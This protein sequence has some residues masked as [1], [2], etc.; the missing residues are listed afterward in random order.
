MRTRNTTFK[1]HDHRP[2]LFRE[3]DRVQVTYYGT[4]S[5]AVGTFVM[6]CTGYL[7]HCMVR[8]DG[9]HMDSRVAV[10]KLSLVSGGPWGSEEDRRNV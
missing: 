5:R 6:Y 2:K 8:W 7:S 10:D 3:G 4:T 1:P 9:T